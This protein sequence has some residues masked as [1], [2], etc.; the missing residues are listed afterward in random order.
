[1]TKDI[2]LISVVGFVYRTPH[3]KTDK[4]GKQYVCFTIVTNSIKETPRPQFHIRVYDQEMMMM[5]MTLERNIK[6]CVTGEYQDAVTVIAGCLLI[7]QKIIA[8]QI[9]IVTVK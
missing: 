2:Y 9:E 1:M 8:S 6:I 3:I 4:E 5:T 7:S